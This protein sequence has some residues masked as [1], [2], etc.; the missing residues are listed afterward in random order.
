VPLECDDRLR[1]ASPSIAF[2][3]PAEAE[4]RI[5]FGCANKVAFGREL[6]RLAQLGPTASRTSSGTARA[7]AAPLRREARNR[8]RHLLLSRAIGL[9]LC[10][11]AQSSSREPVTLNVRH[12]CHRVRLGFEE[13][14]P[15]VGVASLEGSK[16][17]V[18]EVSAATS[19]MS[20]SSSMTATTGASSIPPAMEAGTARRRL[21]KLLPRREVNFR[22]GPDERLHG[23]LEEVEPCV[24][25]S[26]RSA[27]K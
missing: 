10:A 23:R 21:L 9:P 16:S 24:V 3:P 17:C 8:R 13:R 6:S 5:P 7:R 1:G 14:H 15:L 25:Y 19:L 26:F 20:D 11:P 2:S 4:I 27:H 18:R 22:H 12:D